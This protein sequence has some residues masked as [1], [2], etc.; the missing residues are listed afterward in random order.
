M[1]IWN[2]K[3]MTMTVI[4][5]IKR[6]WQYV[7]IV[8]LIAVVAVQCTDKTETSTTT[9]IR[10]VK[11]TDT[12]TEVKIQ[13]IPK[14]VYVNKTKTI[15]GKDSIVYVTKKDSS[16]IK[17]FK[18]DT[19]LESNNAVANLSITTSGELL[20]VSGTIDYKQKE[21]L[22]T[23]VKTINKSAAFIYLEAPVSKEFDRIELGID[24]QYRNKLLIGASVD[25]NNTINKAGFNVK[26]GIKIF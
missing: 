6:Y 22:V 1:K 4:S 23:T 25:Y 21:T 5:F 20:D 2:L 9:E 10:Y 26:L 14:T 8:I 7:A 3:M 11:V 16:T 13:E 15:K 17:A 19:V 12:I 18:Y 24:Y